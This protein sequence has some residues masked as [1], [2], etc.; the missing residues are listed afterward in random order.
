MAKIN[1]ENLYKTLN[2]IDQFIEGKEE[3]KN[4]IKIEENQKINARKSLEKM[5]EITNKVL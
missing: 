4:Q 5:I 3:L 1:I 2:N